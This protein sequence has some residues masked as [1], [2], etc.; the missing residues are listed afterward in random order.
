[1]IYF[2]AVMWTPRG[3]ATVLKVGRQ[4]LRAKR[5]ENF[6]TPHFLASGKTK[7]CLDS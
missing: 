6:L 7:Y 3:D 2:L 5:G 4:I 1:M